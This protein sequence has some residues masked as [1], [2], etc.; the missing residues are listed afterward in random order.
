MLISLSVSVYLLFGFF[1]SPA[2]PLRPPQIAFH[3]MC[4][5]KCFAFSIACPSCSRASIVLIG[6]PLYL[7]NANDLILVLYAARHS[8]CIVAHEM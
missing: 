7:H 2:G 8:H 1:F 5:C 6:F 3:V 4:A